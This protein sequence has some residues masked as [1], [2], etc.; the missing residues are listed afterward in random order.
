MSKTDNNKEI[1]GTKK[2]SD[3]CRL[4]CKA[5]NKKHYK[6]T[7]SIRKDSHHSSE[8]VNLHCFKTTNSMWDKW[9]HYNTSV[10]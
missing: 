6:A 10:S 3:K 7:T 1:Y 5:A 4:R 8:K 2:L 9:T